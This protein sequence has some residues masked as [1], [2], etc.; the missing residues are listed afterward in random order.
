M[1]WGCDLEG[2]DT[3]C[4]GGILGVMPVHTPLLG[5]YTEIRSI[6]PPCRG[7]LSLFWGGR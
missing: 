7:A 2:D 5:A 4:L 6:R 3:Y 1:V